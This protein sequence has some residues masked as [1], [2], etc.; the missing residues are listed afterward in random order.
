MLGHPAPCLPV[1]ASGLAKLSSLLFAG[2]EKGRFSSDSQRQP[3]LPST[4]GAERLPAEASRSDSTESTSL[5]NSQG[6]QAKVVLIEPR[7]P[8]SRYVLSLIASVLNPCLQ[9][10]GFSQTVWYINWFSHYT[11][12]VIQTSYTSLGSL[13][14]VATKLLLPQ[15][16]AVFDRLA[17]RYALTGW[18][19]CHAAMQS[20][21]ILNL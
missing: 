15:C 11:L 9:Q 12:A 17:I 3:E 8:F 7:F 21:H 14:V 13:L 6:S 19:S 16:Q 20:E 4:P 10:Q 18:Q 2:V 1:Q 5:N